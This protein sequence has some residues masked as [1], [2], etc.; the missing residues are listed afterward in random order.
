MTA[1]ANFKVDYKVNQ[2]LKAQKSAAFLGKFGIYFFL[3]YYV[4]YSNHSILLDVKRIT[5]KYR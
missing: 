2:K 1:N 4:D 3:G 5:T